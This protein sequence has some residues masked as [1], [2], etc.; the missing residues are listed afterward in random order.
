MA[1]RGSGRY[2][3]MPSANICFSNF[4]ASRVCFGSMNCLADNAADAAA[5]PPIA[6]TNA[7]NR[8]G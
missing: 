1:A 6:D 8:R 4:V 5:R 7:D 3:L 2:R